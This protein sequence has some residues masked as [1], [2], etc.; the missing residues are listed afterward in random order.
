MNTRITST[1]YLVMF[2]MIAIALFLAFSPISTLAAPGKGN[3]P[4]CKYRDLD[5][6]KI[7]SYNCDRF[8]SKGDKDSITPQVKIV[9]PEHGE[10]IL[11][12]D[13]VEINDS[14]GN[15]LFKALPIKIVVSP[16][17]VIDFAL[18]S[19]AGTQYL[20]LPQIDGVGHL[21]A[22]I[23]NVIRVHE[24]G[25]NITGVDFVENDNRSDMNGGFCVFRNAEP[26]STE[27][28][29]ILNVN[30]P[31]QAFNSMAD[32]E[33]KVSVDFTENSHGPRLKNHP[34]DIPPGDQIVI[35]FMNDLSE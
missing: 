27:E 14:D 28:Y 13:L 18:A 21:H 25:G 12:S 9:K 3:G 8:Q 31:L 32:G 29:Q 30:C 7:I 20:F 11:A 17:F 35:D 33:Y 26:S 2:H 1:K 23:S 16:E 24:V 4:Q 15:F 6:N 5:G 19:S 10:T 34:R 22:Y